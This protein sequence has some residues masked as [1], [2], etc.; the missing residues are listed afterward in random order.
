MRKIRAVLKAEALGWR[1]ASDQLLLLYGRGG[2][3]SSR[4][5]GRS[6]STSSSRSRGSVSS[7]SSHFGGV[8]SSRGGRGCVRTGSRSLNF[9]FF[10]FLRLARRQTSGEGESKGSNF[11]E[12][13]HFGGNF[14]N[15]L[16][17]KH[18]SS[19]LLQKVTRTIKIY[20]SAGYLPPL[21]VLTSKLNEQGQS[22]FLFFDSYRR[23]P[24]CRH[25]RRR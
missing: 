18:P 22:N 11:D 5:S 1:E 7:R 25:P 12:V 9:G 17:R 21:F 6:S 2:R 13:I 23:R 16:T 14:E 20:F 15:G 8:N 4:S 24:D 3:G 10:Y 19:R